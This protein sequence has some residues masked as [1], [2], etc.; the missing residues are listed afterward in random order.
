[1]LVTAITA[2]FL[3]LSSNAGA[4]AILAGCNQEGL[5]IDALQYFDGK[6]MQDLCS[7]LHVVEGMPLPDGGLQLRLNNL[8]VN[9][10]A[11]AKMNLSSA[12]YVVKRWVG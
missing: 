8:G 6:G 4:L 11:L 10:S 3:F 1:L 2:A 5:I 9:V 12:C 7:G